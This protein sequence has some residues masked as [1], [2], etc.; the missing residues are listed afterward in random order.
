MASWPCTGSR[1]GKIPVKIISGGQSG[2]DR[3]ALDAALALGFDYGG[4]CP[5]GGLAEDYPHPPGLLAAYPALEEIPSASY[6][7][8]TRRNVRDADATLVIAPDAARAKRGGTGHT[9]DCVHKLRKDYFITLLDDPDH[10]RKTLEWLAN[11]DRRSTLNVAGPRESEAPGIAARAR[12]LLRGLLRELP[13]PPGT[14]P[15]PRKCRAPP[16]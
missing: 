1:P 12:D 11:L 6:H 16:G 10:R 7:E 14:S 13:R 3:G 2:V 15:L 8:R 4:W 9:L 5:R